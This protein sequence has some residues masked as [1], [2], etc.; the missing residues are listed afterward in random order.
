MAKLE[1]ALAL[2]ASGA[3]LESSSLSVRTIMINFLHTFIPNPILINLGWLTIY[4]YG[5]FMVLGIGGGLIVSL[6]LSPK[7]KIK[8]DDLLDLAFWLI[9]GGL[10]G[11]RLYDCLLNL[12]YYLQYPLDILKIRNGGLAIHGALIGGAIVT[13]LYTKKL[14]KINN[15]GRGQ[16]FLR[17]AALLAPALALGQFFGR[18]GNYF[19]QEIFGRPTN[20]PWGIP[21][22]LLNRPNNFIGSEF[23]H[24]TFI[25]EALGN[26]IIFIILILLIKYFIKNNLLNNRGYKIIIATYLLAYSTLRFLLEFIRVDDTPIIIGVRL[27]QIVSLIIIVLAIY[28]LYESKNQKQSG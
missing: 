16:L 21:I 17:L 10:I 2:G 25:Y 22:S 14:A 1:D 26:L 5:L 11:A 12:P 20:L 19:N 13:W 18:F 15:E 23:F 24:P 9:I 8:N 6:I 3:I 4:W 7:F 27:P 28:L